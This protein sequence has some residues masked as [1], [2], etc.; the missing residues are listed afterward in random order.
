MAREAQVVLGRMP[1][2][3]RLVGAAFA[4][5]AAYICVQMLNDALVVRNPPGTIPETRS[6][7]R[8]DACIPAIFAL[9]GLAVVLIR[10]RRMVVASRRAVVR[11]IGWG[12]WVQVTETPLTS[13]TGITVH[14]AEYRGEGSGRYRIV[15]VVAS[16]P[17]GEQEL[18]APSTRA[19]ARI[20]ARRIAAALDLPVSSFPAATAGDQAFVARRASDAELRMPTPTA[21]RVE[22]TPH[23]LTIIM[24]A[25]LAPR[26]LL[27]VLPVL[28]LGGFAI[29]AG[30]TSPVQSP[31]LLMLITLIPI[32]AA[33][34]GLILASH[35]W[36]STRI[37]IEADGS[38]RIGRIPLAA[39]AIRAM[40][41][42]IEDDADGGL[43][44]ALDDRELRVGYGL[45]SEELRWI[46]A[47]VG[48]R[49]AALDHQQRSE[50]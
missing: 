48:D 17:A 37:L 31:F 42:T 15:P 10:Y 25:R 36:F 43:V 14:E 30:T 46:R 35:W 24:P 13:T 6:P 9:A 32:A 38:L 3:I 22:E 19:R 27:L 44:I 33:L 34:A 29:F 7:S 20:L 2:G 26:I 8:I 28:T 4:A 5:I 39:S 21:I 12:P 16:S 50:T 11:E 45:T 49:L 41:P 23:S 40:A 1:L 18:A 47:V